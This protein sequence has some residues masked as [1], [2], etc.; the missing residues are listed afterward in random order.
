MS[1]TTVSSTNV[2]FMG[3]FITL[4]LRTDRPMKWPDV[5]ILSYHSDYVLIPECPAH[6]DPAKR[7]NG[8]EFEKELN[9]FTDYFKKSISKKETVR[10]F[11]KNPMTYNTSNGLIAIYSHDNVSVAKIPFIWEETL[12][13][14]GYKRDE[15][16]PVPF[17]N[18]EAYYNSFRDE[19][20]AI[21]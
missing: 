5:H 6:H 14:I 17:A 16:L 20:L 2:G 10:M 9:S 18:G 21:W 4:R 11:D 19:L 13:V 12:K 8:K 3:A 7:L 15:T 1:N